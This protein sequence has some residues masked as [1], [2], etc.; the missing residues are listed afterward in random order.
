MNRI[1]PIDGQLEIEQDAI[2]SILKGE[3]GRLSSIA[4]YP[5]SDKNDKLDLLANT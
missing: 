1:T 2:Q 5:K 4:E 3:E